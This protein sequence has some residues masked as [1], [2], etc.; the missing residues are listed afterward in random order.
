[1]NINSKTKR[2][3]KIQNIIF[4]VL[5][6]VVVILLAKF[7]LKTNVS[8]DWTANNRHTLSETTTGLLAQLQDDITIQAF[9]STNNDYRED[10]ESLLSRY[11][12]YSDKLNIEYINPDFSPDLVRQHNIQQQGELVVSRGSQQTHVFDLS[13]QS[14]TNALISVSRTK[15]QWIVFI[16]GHG[17]RSPFGKENYNL[18]TWG[19]QLKKKG[20]KFQ[21]LNLVEHSQIPTNTA[22][23]IIASPERSWLDGEIGIIQDYIANGGNLLWLAD[24]KTHQH[25]SALAEQLGLEFIPGTIIDPNA[26]LLGIDAPT[27]SLI[28]DYANH[29]IGEATSSV[30]LYPKAIA[31]EPSSTES[32]WQQLSLLNSQANTWSKATA[33]DK[34]M[35][36]EFDLGV[37]SSG[38]FSLGYLLTR[39]NSEQDTNE[40][41]IAVIGDSDFISNSYIGNAANLELGIALINWLTQDDELIAIPVK[42]TID[43]SLNLSRTQSM[44]IGLGFLIVVPLVLF[45][46]A[47]LIWR[48]RRQR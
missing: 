33:I 46:I 11:Q 15:E 10:L 45:L 41:R 24:P 43:N 27:F 18:S 32:E 37:D 25:L 40:Q 4:Y 48:I 5:L 44:V 31:L 20:F 39:I 2:Q 14:L 1:M 9:I 35:L 12:K 13:E 6:I 30:T 22:A 47:F 34:N 8:A 17:E 36:L 28:N 7:S 19:E 16:E 38:P 29:P 42:T 23:I 3:L 26:Q 21:A